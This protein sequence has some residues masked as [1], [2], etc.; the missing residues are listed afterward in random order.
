[1]RTLSVLAIIV[2]LPACAGEM[3][4]RS[5]SSRSAGIL[6]QY[7]S[8][9]QEFAARQT[10]SNAANASRINR[11]SELRDERTTEIQSRIRSWRVAGNER[12]LSGFSTL[13]AT[14]A[15]AIIASLN[16]AP[17]ASA[18][19][20]LRFDAAPVDSV[21]KQLVEL[22][23]PRTPAEQVVGVVGFLGSLRSAYDS[24]VTAAS[25]QTAAA[26]TDTAGNTEG[27]AE[28]ANAST[29]PVREN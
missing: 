16:P 10:E 1:M 9:F 26:T 20:S 25:G 7:R 27:A 11:L 22:Q 15:E 5:V 23:Q 4:M 6:N 14:N 17:S 13:A 29:P 19:K 3:A 18:G 24:A 8:V 28:R 21:I 2:T 12:A